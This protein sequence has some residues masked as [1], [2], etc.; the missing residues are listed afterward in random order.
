MKDK[1]INLANWRKVL[2]CPSWQFQTLVH[3]RCT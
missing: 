2:Y 3:V 1:S